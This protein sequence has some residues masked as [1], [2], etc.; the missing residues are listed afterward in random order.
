MRVFLDSNVWVYS[1]LD[2][3]PLKQT[4]A[5]NLIDSEQIVLSHQVLGEV[6]NVLLRVGV[7]DAVNEKTLGAAI[8]RSTLVERGLEAYSE[9]LAL[10]KRYKLSY[11]DSLLLIDALVGGCTVFYTEDLH[12]GQ[13]IEG[14]L[15]IVN[16]FTLA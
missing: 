7:E 10:R 9:A 8:G 12:D 6:S 14:K 2:Q 3:D 1:I 16:P 4:K 5:L 11:W 13:L 15:K